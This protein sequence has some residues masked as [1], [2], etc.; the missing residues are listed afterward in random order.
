MSNLIHLKE[1]DGRHLAYTSGITGRKGNGRISIAYLLVGPD[2]RELFRE[3][4]DTP[5][6]GSLNDAEYLGVQELAD[7]LNTLPPVDNLFLFCS[8]KLVVNQLRGAWR[9][10]VDRHQCFVSKIKIR[11]RATN[12]SVNWVPGQSNAVKQW[13]WE[14]YN[15]RHSE[16]KPC[17][18]VC[19]S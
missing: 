14:K 19:E 12:W 13:H 8:S 9:I 3:F 11:L 2:G 1:H 17:R 16:V 15:T 6:W 10:N 7:A 5:Y 4:H 18:E